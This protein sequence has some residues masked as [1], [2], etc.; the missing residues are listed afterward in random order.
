MGPGERKRLSAAI[1]G[2]AAELGFDLC[3]IARAGKLSDDG[4]IL[5]QW[6]KAGM[7]AGMSFLQ[8]DISVRTNPELL[9]EGARTVVVTGLCYHSEMQ[10]KDPHAPVLSRHA[11]GLN[12]HDVVS[13]K[14]G[15]L[16]ESVR[17]PD[18]GIRGRIFCDSGPLLEKAWARMAGLGW[19]GRHS[20]LINKDIGSYFFTG[21]LILD[22]EAEYDRPFEDNLCGSCRACIEA[23]PTG[24]INDDY[25]IDARKCIAY[26]TIEN[27]GPIAEEIICR[28][29]GRVYGCDACQEVCPWNR[30][31]GCMTH[32]EF[33]L[34][35]E[36]AAMTR[37]EWLSLDRED[38]RKL[39]RDTTAGRVKY[40]NFV[41]NIR[42]AVKSADCQQ[43]R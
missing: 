42:A 19:P 11:Y 28:L 12:Y 40:D 16:L 41:R 29:G 14:L 37:E 30:Q 39:F 6:C 31:T 21:I 24:A 38:Y 22:V 4:R 35:E 23:C 20:V 26:Q 36:I 17:M 9:L 32:P 33:R 2:R 25:T 8:R 15:L 5:E 7:N 13:G 3:G 27:K 10:Q 1:K 43:S 18:P 34:N